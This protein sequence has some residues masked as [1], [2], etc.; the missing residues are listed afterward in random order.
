MEDEPFLVDVHRDLQRRGAVHYW[1]VSG[2]LEDTCGS[3]Q[4][5]GADRLGGFEFPFHQNSA[6][7]FE[8]PLTPESS[9]ASRGP[10][11]GIFGSLWLT[12]TTRHPFFFV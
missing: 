10:V 8:Y 6:K 2:I 11:A 3:I 5:A 7:N 9:Y 4:Q 1:V 12:S